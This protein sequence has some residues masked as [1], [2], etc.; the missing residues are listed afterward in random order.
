MKIL[1]TIIILFCA[2]FVASADELTYSNPIV[3]Q[4][5]EN[6]ETK[7]ATPDVPGFYGGASIW[8]M[9]SDGSN[10]KL[11]TSWGWNWSKTS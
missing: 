7:T 1:V 9:E 3:F 8:I 2:S 10:P 11:L 5:F 4:R 6:N